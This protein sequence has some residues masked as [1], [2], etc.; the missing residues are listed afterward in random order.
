MTNIIFFFIK[1]SENFLFT[2][3]KASYEAMV[4]AIPRTT[5]RQDTGRKA[6]HPISTL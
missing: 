6:L 5:Q 2:F 4:T 1:T 3:V